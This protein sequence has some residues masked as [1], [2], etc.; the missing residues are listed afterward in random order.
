MKIQLLGTSF[1]IESDED[2]Q[3][4]NQVI[5]QFEQKIEEIRKSV[6]T[7]D[8]LKIAILAGILISDE[9]VKLREHG[10]N[11]E[12]SEEI[13]RIAEKLI[14]ELDEHLEPTKTQVSPVTGE[15]ETL[16]S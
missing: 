4:L 6:S 1:S 12:Q 5:R 8:P 10:G 2:P 14:A 15:I 3:Y 9:V 11:P 7:K 13:S 16:E